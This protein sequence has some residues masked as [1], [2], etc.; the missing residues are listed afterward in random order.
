MICNLRD[1]LAVS[2]VTDKLQTS[3][4]QVTG[5]EVIKYYIKTFELRRVDYR[6]FAFLALINA[7]KVIP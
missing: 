6:S 3:Y 5:S 4:R 1:S 7:I 2:Q